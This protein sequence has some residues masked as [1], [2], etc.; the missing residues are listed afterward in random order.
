VEAGLP[1]SQR[2]PLACGLTAV[3]FSKDESCCLLVSW[4][5]LQIVHWDLKEELD[6]QG[7]ACWG[8]SCALRGVSYGSLAV[9]TLC[10]SLTGVVSHSPGACSSPPPHPRP[11]KK[12]LPLVTVEITGLTDG[13][14]SFLAAL[15]PLLFGPHLLVYCFLIAHAVTS[16]CF[17]PRTLLD[18]GRMQQKEMGPAL[19]EMKLPSPLLLSVLPGFL[20][21]SPACVRASGGF[22]PFSARPA[23]PTAPPYRE[24]LH[25]LGH[26]M[27]ALHVPLNQSP[28]LIVPAFCLK[29]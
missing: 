6:G 18:S 29:V 11:C 1:G 2:Q 21:L 19:W 26:L 14:A 5:S 23:L 16:A 10:S 8:Q 25:A 15:R 17:V 20:S 24:H 7:S 27:V 22:Y 4:L 12:M 3:L 28:N 13:T 9:V